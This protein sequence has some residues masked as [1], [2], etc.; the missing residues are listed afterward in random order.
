MHWNAV[1]RKSNGY[2][3]I[4]EKERGRQKKK[5]GYRGLGIT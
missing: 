5:F 2:Q 1:A 3:T 4:I